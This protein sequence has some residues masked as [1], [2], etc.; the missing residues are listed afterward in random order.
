MKRAVP[1]LL[2]LL[3][4]ACASFSNPDSERLKGAMGI[5]VTPVK[6]GEATP[7]VSYSADVLMARAE[8]YFREK[9]FAEA[10]QEYGRFMELHATHPWA[11]YALYQ[12]GLCLM[13]QVKTP[14]REPELNRQALQAFENLIANYPVSP[15]VEDARRMRDEARERL[16]RHEL[17]V[18]SF[19]L[20][21]GRPEAAVARLDYLIKSYP[22]TPGA[23]DAWLEMGLA[24]AATGDDAGAAE[25]LHHF[26]DGNPD[27][28][29][30]AKAKKALA[31]LE[32]G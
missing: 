23:A 24:R 1:A 29:R 21:T 16:A 3:C 19:Y 9:Q 27:P 7:D 2:L 8:G 11:P 28:K 4:A 18:A 14:D 6:V 12:Q 26:L 31:A 17:G 32:A 5:A 13:F 30:A 15:A 22:G 10:A 20:R 25:A